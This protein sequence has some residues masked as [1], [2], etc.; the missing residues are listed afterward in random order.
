MT[1]MGPGMP[2]KRKPLGPTIEALAHMQLEPNECIFDWTEN[3]DG[4][5]RVRLIDRELQRM[6]QRNRLRRGGHGRGLEFR[7]QDGQWV[8]SVAGWIS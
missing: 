7:W 1:E 6:L 8:V 4:V 3:R 5:V 2:A